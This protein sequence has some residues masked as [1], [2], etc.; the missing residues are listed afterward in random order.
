VRTKPTTGGIMAPVRLAVLLALSVLPAPDS[1]LLHPPAAARRPAPAGYIIQDA[2]RGQW[3]RASHPL[4]RLDAASCALGDATVVDAAL[5]FRGRTAAARCRGRTILQQKQEPGDAGAPEPRLGSS[6]APGRRR[7]NRSALTPASIT[8]PVAASGVGRELT[9]LRKIMHGCVAVMTVLVGFVLGAS[10]LAFNVL[11]YFIQRKRRPMAAY[12]ASWIVHRV[13]VSVCEEV[14]G[15][16]VRV[17]AESSLK[18]L[19]GEVTG[20]TIMASRVRLLDVS[21]GDVGIYTDDVRFVQTARN[22]SLSEQF[23]AMGSASSRSDGVMELI[24]PQP[25]SLQAS[26]SG[27]GTDGGKLGG[28]REGTQGAVRGKVGSEFERVEAGGEGEDKGRGGGEESGGLTVAEPFA[29]SLVASLTEKDVNESPPIM[30]I[31][32]EL[33]TFLVRFGLSIG[34]RKTLGGDQWR[35]ESFNSTSVELSYVKLCKDNTLRVDAALALDRQA[36]A[37]AGGP[38][39]LPLTIRLGLD[40]EDDGRCII[41]RQPEL[42]TKGIFQ[43]EVFVPFMPLARSGADLGPD[44]HLSKLLVKEGLIEAEGIVVV[45]PPTSLTAE[46]EISELEGG[47]AALESEIDELRRIEMARRERDSMLKGSHVDKQRMQVEGEIRM[48]RWRA[49]E[50]RRRRNQRLVTVTEATRKALSP[51]DSIRAQV[52]RNSTTVVVAVESFLSLLPSLV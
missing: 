7:P 6:R 21:V 16:Q 2:C 1:A 22:G 20:I 33:L 25:A 13:L 11:N 15:L 50:R 44:F 32:K 46:Q 24:S 37:R 29:A 9:S 48:S 19:G 45:R 40:L 3:V 4:L 31:L 8:P 12:I 17:D 23:M 42:V 28:D 10:Q 38:A 51:L 35:E 49:A 41:V 18:L 39:K 26:P 27:D 30:Y 14:Q 52:S 5:V 43:R 34:A 36:G 47:G